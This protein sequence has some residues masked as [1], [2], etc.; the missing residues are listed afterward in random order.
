[1][2]AKAEKKRLRHL[3]A[4]QRYFQAH[5]GELKHIGMTWPIPLLKKIDEAAVAAGVSRRAWLL[6]LCER[7]IARLEKRRKR[8]SG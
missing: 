4:V 8:K 3:E 6:A 2:D 5:K 7:E 1:M